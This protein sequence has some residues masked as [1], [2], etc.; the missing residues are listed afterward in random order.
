MR[1][2]KRRSKLSITGSH[3][4]CMLANML[5]SLIEYGRIETSI[6]KAK[7]LKRHADK[8]ITIA[9]KENTIHAKRQAKAKLMIRYNSLTSKE[10]RKV[11]EKDLSSYNGDRKV[12]NKLFTH[13]KDRYTTRNGGYTRIIKKENMRKGDGSQTCLIEYIE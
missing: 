8:M 5:K 10:K 13:L 7:E 3:K 9:K 2:L 11:K 12:I 1:H 6:V 4:R